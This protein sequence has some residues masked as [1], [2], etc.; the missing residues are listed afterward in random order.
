MTKH[1]PVEGVY[2]SG[3]PHIEHDCDDKS[4]VESGAFTTDPPPKPKRAKASTE[5][6]ASA[7][8][9]DSAKE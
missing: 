7:G 9:L 8:S 2:L 3:V 6:P 4:H 1:Y 5:D